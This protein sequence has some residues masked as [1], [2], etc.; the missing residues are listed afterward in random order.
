MKSE[1]S[2]VKSENITASDLA[3]CYSIALKSLRWESLKWGPLLLSTR[4]VPVGLVT[5]HG[6]QFQVQVVLQGV[7]DEWLEMEDES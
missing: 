1:T 7:E 4:R 3:A 2:K 5:K 6:R